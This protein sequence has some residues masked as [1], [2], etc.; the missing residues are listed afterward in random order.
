NDDQVFF[1][2]WSFQQPSSYQWFGKQPKIPDR[3]K[4]NVLF[5]DP[6]GFHIR[7]D[8]RSAGLKLNDNNQRIFE[9]P[10]RARIVADFTYIFAIPLA[11]INKETHI[12]LS[13]GTKDPQYANTETGQGVPSF[14]SYFFRAKVFPKNQRYAPNFIYRNTSGGTERNTHEEL[15]GNPRQEWMVV[16]PLL[17]VGT[18]LMS[19]QDYAFTFSNLVNAHLMTCVMFG[20]AKEEGDILSMVFENMPGVFKQSLGSEGVGWGVTG[21]VEISTSRDNMISQYNFGGYLGG[22]Y[23][24]ASGEQTTPNALVHGY[25][26]PLGRNVFGGVYINAQLKNGLR[27]GLSYSEVQGKFPGQTNKVS[28]SDHLHPFS[29]APS[30]H[31][32]IVIRVGLDL[33]RN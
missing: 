17:F 27:F 9:A 32:V 18:D 33:N 30:D 19:E 22:L 15:N 2:P 14:A 8:G 16:V 26:Y 1:L 23:S 12:D 20:K 28:N 3:L 25:P 24:T 21:E 29:G 31:G 5:G 7:V 10:W 6:K 11:A 13:V 4:Q